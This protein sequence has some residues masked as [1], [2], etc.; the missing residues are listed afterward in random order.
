MFE[1]RSKQKYVFFTVFMITQLVMHGG[2][3]VLKI[4]VQNLLAMVEMIA[5]LQTS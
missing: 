3:S 5:N 4:P 1:E 2:T